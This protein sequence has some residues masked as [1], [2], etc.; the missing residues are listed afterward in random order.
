[1]CEMQ[2]KPLI[3]AIDQGSSATK[4][5][6]VD[7]SS[8]RVIS[9]GRASVRSLKARA[10]IESVRVAVT[11][12]LRSAPRRPS[13]VVI[14]IA[15]QRSTLCFF[16][17]QGSPRGDVIPW[18][19]LTGLNPEDCSAR[20]RGEFR[21][22][23]GLPLLPNWWAGKL[24]HELGNPERHGLRYGT[25]DTL[26]LGF[27]TRGATWATDLSNAART[28]L[29]NLKRRVR[30][31]ELIRLFDL[32][33]LALPVLKPSVA[34]FGRVTAGVLPV[35]GRIV[36]VAGDA[37]MSLAGGTGGARGVMNATLGTGG[38]LHLPVFAS[39]KPP[40]GVYL[41][42]AWQAARIHW[43]LEASVGPLNK[44]LKSGLVAAGL[45]KRSAR[46]IVPTPASEGVM[47]IL[48]PDGFGALGPAG[49]GVRFIGGWKR[50]SD[51]EKLG[52]LLE[53]L[54]LLLARGVARF[55]ERPRCIVAG[56]GLSRIPFLL[57]RLADLTGCD[58][59]PLESSETTAWGAVRLAARS[60][61]Q[62][63]PPLEAGDAIA[64]KISRSERDYRI[65]RFESAIRK[66]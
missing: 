11:A 12:A 45:E 31:L 43:A 2:A 50:L 61:G 62:D 63:L 15:N 23:T 13:E 34:E 35:G 3:L 8:G 33:G 47:A 30:G 17:H 7:P 65:K 56:G 19:A 64:P 40:D 6:L 46:R 42:P 55:P 29:V 14:A 22:A 4:T 26:L 53:G 5:V 21:A 48:A 44:A 37:G 27:L 36:A 39:A 9:T 16:D 20:E 54:A 59:A 60:L 10:I 32:D 52:A 41:A 51:A 28:G 58:V 38:F 24:A 57:Q 66:L 1:M 25:V 18:W 49:K